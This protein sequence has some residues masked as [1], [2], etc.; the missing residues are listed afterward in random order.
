MI[1]DFTLEEIM[2]LSSIKRWSVIE[3]SRD[4]SV[5]EHSYNVAMISMA[6]TKELGFSNFLSNHILEWSLLHDLPELVTGDIP[7]PTKR[8]MLDII[9][10][11][12]KELFPKLTGKKSI[13][14]YAVAPV[15]KIA[16]YIDAIQYAKKFCIDS[17]KE[18]IV[19]EMKSNL[20]S[21]TCD[22]T[23]YFGFHRINLHK[24]IHT[25]CKDVKMY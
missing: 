17:R 7:T 10:E 22:A 1:C 4:Q 5:A 14:I 2:R 9:N 21:S 18:K 8:H 3:M 16:D 20:F 19:T 23:R 6:I 15:V 13:N 24:V 25:I 12:E 11:M